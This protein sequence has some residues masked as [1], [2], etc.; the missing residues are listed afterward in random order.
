VAQDLF[1]GRLINTPQSLC[2]RLSDAQAGHFPVF[3]SYLFDERA[4]RCASCADVVTQVRYC[5]NVRPS[6]FTT[7]FPSGFVIICNAVRS[8]VERSS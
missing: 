8:I 3:G 2:L 1:A 5:H 6:G 7:F 4:N